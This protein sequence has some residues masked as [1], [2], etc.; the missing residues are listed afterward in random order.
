MRLLFQ[1]FT[2]RLLRGPPTGYRDF[3]TARLVRDYEQ[4]LFTE[5]VA[6][7]EHE[8]R[9]VK[10]LVGGNGKPLIL[11][12]RDVVIAAGPLIADTKR[13]RSVLVGRAAHRRTTV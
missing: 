13:P 2:V 12:D 7:A 5:V 3:D 4:M 9:P 10:V 6:V 1:V 11:C 8:G